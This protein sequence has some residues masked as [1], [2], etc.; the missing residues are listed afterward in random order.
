MQLLIS[1][2][3]CFNE[4]WL[5]VKQH[6]CCHCGCSVAW[7]GYAWKATLL[8]SQQEDCAGQ[9]WQ[10]LPWGTSSRWNGPCS[11]ALTEIR[12]GLAKGYKLKLWICQ[13]TFFFPLPERGI[14]VQISF[15][16]S[17]TMLQCLS[18]AFTL[19]NSFLLFRQLI[20]TCVLFL[21]DCVKTE[22]GP[23]LNSSSS[24]FDNSSGVISDFGLFATA[25]QCKS[26]F[27]LKPLMTDTRKADFV[28]RLGEEPIPPNKNI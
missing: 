22:S 12:W 16:F 4:V 13:V 7:V 21:T 27:V 10:S 15:T 18:K 2:L 1:P 11:Q 3:P 26:R 20:N 25:L 28:V 8:M 17:R 23:V 5:S 9:G 14:S 6:F 19:P 24:L